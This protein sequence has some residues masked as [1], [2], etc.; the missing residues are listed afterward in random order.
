MPMTFRALEG[1]KKDKTHNK[2]L[3]LLHGIM[4]FRIII[5][6]YSF[7][8]SAVVIITWVSFMSKICKYGQI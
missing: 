7:T 2:P 3:R 5:S 8:V 4:C 6:L 1:T